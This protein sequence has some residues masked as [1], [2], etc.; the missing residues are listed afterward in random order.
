MCVDEENIS[1]HACWG[2]SL[3][4]TVLVFSSY[5][6][7]YHLLLRVARR[8]YSVEWGQLRW[9]SLFCAWCDSSFYREIG[10]RD[11]GGPKYKTLYNR[12]RYV[13]LWYSYRLSALSCG[14]ARFFG[15]FGFFFGIARGGGPEIILINRCAPYRCIY[16]TPRIRRVKGVG[17]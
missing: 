11:G 4:F 2:A 16:C 8:A 7:S 13:I 1:R 15:G 9:L 14:G 6:L 5:L 10:E 12:Q 3:F 17:E